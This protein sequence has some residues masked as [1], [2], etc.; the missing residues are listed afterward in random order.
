MGDPRLNSLHLDPTRRQDFRRAR[1]ALLQSRGNETIYAER[2]RGE[3]SDPGTTFIHNRGS[4]PPPTLEVWLVD[5]EYI[6]PLKIG[7]NTMGRSADNDVVV[8][9]LYVSRR[10]CAVLVHH[11]NTCVLQDVASKNGTILNGSRVSQPS[12]VIADDVLEVGGSVVTLTHNEGALAELHRE[13]DGTVRFNKPPRKVVSVSKPAFDV[14]EEPAKPAVRHFSVLVVLAPLVLGVVIAVAA[15]SV[16]FL[17]FS[18][19]SPVMLAAN[20]QPAFSEGSKTVFA[21]FRILAVSAM[22]RTPQKTM[23]SL[24]VV[25]ARRARSSESPT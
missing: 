25:A 24:S 12:A 7:L 16:Y 10:H 21:G 8:E 6:Y 1:E 23:M 5:R 4:A 19:A 15:N 13:G 20:E 9:D 3:E 14:P 22:N 17:L 18:L 2:K 11:D